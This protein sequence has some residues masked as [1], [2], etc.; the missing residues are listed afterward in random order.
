MKW[1]A[2]GA[3][4][5][6]LFEALQ[7]PMP[8]QKIDFS[9]NINPLGPPRI[10]KEKWDQLYDVVSDYPDPKGYQL[11]KKLAIK[12]DIRE[13]QIL[14]GNG[15]AEI[16]SLIGRMLA[17][18]RVVIVQP[19]FSEYEEACRINGCTI[20]YHQL[21]PDNWE[22]Q[23][24]I[25]SKLK[26]EDALFFCNPSNPTGVFYPKT[27]VLELIKACEKNDCLM[28]VDEAFYDF[29]TD[30]ESIV[31][32]INTYPNLLII[33][34]M[35]KMFAI[36]G[37][38]LGYLMADPSVIEELSAF[39]PQWSMNAL[40]LMAGEWCLES[41]SHMNET[42]SM[43]KQ[44]RERLFGF[45]KENGFQ[46][47]PSQIN[48][49]LLKDPALKEQLPLFQF[50]IE[51]GIIPRHTMNFPGLKGEWLRF[52]IKGSEDNSRLMEAIEVWRSSHL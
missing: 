51:R 50:L 4:P 8:D 15:G 36:P 23:E 24:G 17:G 48:F 9:A 33:R 21:E 37:L 34:S 2:H 43:I 46:F 35:T 47:S 29:L 12:E 31:P 49:Y 20:D 44:E 25:A 3:N 11:K 6:Y 28:I 40:A 39:Q 10:L 42:R 27:L 52:A 14:I 18:K 5:H 19:A 38:R 41:E 16:I 45:Y 30:Y 13:S 1:P 7:I 32:Y 26:K 22:W